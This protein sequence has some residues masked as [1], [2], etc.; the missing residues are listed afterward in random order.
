LEGKDGMDLFGQ[1]RM[2]GLSLFSGIGG[3]D[4]ALESWVR[5][6]AYCENDRYAQSVLLSRMSEGSL[7]CAPIC[8]DV[9]E[10]KGSEFNNAG[11]GID[12]ICGGFPCQNISCA[13]NGKGLA[14]E[15]SGLFFEIVRLTKE[16][17][18]KF[19]FLENVPAIRTRGLR[20]VIR[21]FAD[22]RYDCRWTCVSAAEVGAPH[23][24]KR[25]FLLAHARSER[26]QQIPTSAHGNEIKNEGWSEKEMHI[27]QCDGKGDR[28]GI[29]AYTSS[30]RWSQDEFHVN[31]ETRIRKEGRQSSGCSEAIA[32]D[33]EAGAKF[34]G[35]DDGLSERLDSLGGTLG[36]LDEGSESPWKEEFPADQRVVEGGQY[37]VDRL[38]C[39]GNSVVPRQVREAFK[40]LMGI[41]SPIMEKK[42]T[43]ELADFSAFKS[44]VLSKSFSIG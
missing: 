2:Q 33:R 15:Q 36:G 5:P 19:V 34:C 14:G 40:R 37:R 23:L 9:K 31:S 10:L 7:P 24:R 43:M 22:L 1:E 8:T 39:L 13:G 35:V 17:K 29:V 26:R 41:E 32:W 38:K 11:I 12:I 42:R 3:I 21:A 18:P 4:L 44:R 25:W 16:I 27:S 20:E 28:D 6:I 30:G